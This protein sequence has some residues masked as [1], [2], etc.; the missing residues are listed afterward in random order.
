MIHAHRHVFS[1]T[2]SPISFT[3]IPLLD[4]AFDPDED[5]ALQGEFSLLPHT[6]EEEVEEITF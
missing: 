6:P 4:E 3:S 2:D 5:E 1:L